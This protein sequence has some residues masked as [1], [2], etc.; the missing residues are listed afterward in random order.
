MQIERLDID[1][2]EAALPETGIELFH[3]PEALS[4]LEEHVDG[5]L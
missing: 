5:E 3:R 1:E 2:W 4:V